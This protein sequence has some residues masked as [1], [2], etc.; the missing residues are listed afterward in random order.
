[1]EEETKKVANQKIRDLLNDDENPT[2]MYKAIDLIKAIN[3]PLKCE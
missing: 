2:S 3:N 1:M